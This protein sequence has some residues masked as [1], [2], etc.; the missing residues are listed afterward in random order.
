MEK[1][2]NKIELTLKNTNNFLTLESKNTRYFNI[3]KLSSHIDLND[4]IKKR[5]NTIKALRKLNIKVSQK[6]NTDFLKEIKP[7]YEQLIEEQI[8]QT[9]KVTKLVLKIYQNGLYIPTCDNI[10]LQNAEKENYK[11]N[12]FFYRNAFYSRVEEIT[13][14]VEGIITR[15]N[16]NNLNNMVEMAL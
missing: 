3:K 8:Q 7:N 9:Q 16:K 11:L 13:S 6:R 12:P 15:I 5:N 14:R 1:Q 4:L 10:E 2:K